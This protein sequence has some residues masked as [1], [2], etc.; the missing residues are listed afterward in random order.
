MNPFVV[1]AG[2]IAVYLLVNTSLGY[3]KMVQGKPEKYH[4][5]HGEKVYEYQ[6]QETTGEVMGHTI[7]YGD[8]DSIAKKGII[9]D[10]VLLFI[11]IIGL[12][13]GIH[14]K[15]N[16][17]G[18]VGILAALLLM[19]ENICEYLHMTGKGMLHNPITSFIPWAIVLEAVMLLAILVL[20]F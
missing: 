3:K 5:E 15:A 2:I 8:K 19:G 9:F 16:P 7:N 14:Q 12:G 4:F 13:F 18:Y 20:M 6:Q 17:I 11:I 10:F 1:I